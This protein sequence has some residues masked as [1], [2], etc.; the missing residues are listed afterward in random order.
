MRSPA[1]KIIAESWTREHNLEAWI[2]RGVVR[3]VLRG[4]PDEIRRGVLD[5]VPFRGESERKAPCKEGRRCSILSRGLPVD[6]LKY[7]VGVSCCSVVA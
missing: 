4:V 2:R 3:G 7:L 6:S 1:W 5:A